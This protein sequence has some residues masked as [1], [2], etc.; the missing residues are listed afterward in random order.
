M[1]ISI[2]IPAY[3]AKYLAQ[4]IESVLNQT[5]NDFELIIVNDQ[6]P[7]DIT[8]IV[9]SFN[10]RR[11]RY[12]INDKNIGGN[13]PVANWNK[14]LSYAKGEF[15]AMICDDDLYESTFLEEMIN[16]TEKYPSC[17]VFHSR[18]QVID[19][20]NDVVDFFPSN[21]EWESV[22]DY[23]WH[24]SHS[25]R[26]QTVSE[27]LYRRKHILECGGYEP[28]PVA[29]GADY[30]SVMKF[31]ALGG[32]VTSNKKLVT[33]R[34]SG[35]NISNSYSSHILEKMM[36]TM[37]YADKML[38][39]ISLNK[40]NGKLLNPCVEAIRKGELRATINV[41]DW[42]NFFNIVTKRKNFNLS[43]IDLA[44]LALKKIVRS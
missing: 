28:I 8:S 42:N 25:M 13:D 34:R 41:C 2:A 3:K 43:L 7:E 24:V 44:K 23:I 1:K 19:K 5:F 4:A 16:L 26:K 32:I 6:S 31:G 30:F 21:P 20:N 14:C 17:N 38:E 18:V 15:F 33:F 22:E 37:V 12:Y 10:D 35:I 9:K 36:G 29:W 39:L 27:W 40:W 11:I